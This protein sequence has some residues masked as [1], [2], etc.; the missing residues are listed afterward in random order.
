M[1][2]K[3]WNG[4][5]D[6]GDDLIVQAEENAVRLH[7]AK[8]RSMLKKV[9]AACVLVAFSIALPLTIISMLA[10]KDSKTGGNLVDTSRE[11]DGGNI[12]LPESTKG[13]ETALKYELDFENKTY[14]IKQ[15]Q[16][17]TLKYELKD[18]I[19]GNLEINIKTGQLSQDTLQPIILDNAIENNNTIKIPL[20]HLV[21]I[22]SGRIFISFKYKNIVMGAYESE[23]KSDVF[24][25]ESVYVPFEI[26]GENIVFG[27]AVDK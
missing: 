16:N 18:L 3:I 20:E 14:N 10:T 23:L 17:I 25:L 4:I 12:T 26:Q 9:A 11:L 21:S 22:N 2:D 7:F 6:L 24:E 27:K 8:K 19:A 13:W 15:T 5:Q 1:S